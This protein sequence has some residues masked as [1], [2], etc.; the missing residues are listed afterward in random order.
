MDEQKSFDSLLTSL[1]ILGCMEGGDFIGTDNEKNIYCRY[2]SNWWNT[3][4]DL[5]RFETWTCTHDALKKIYCFDLPEYIKHANQL[6]E[7][8]EYIF[9]DL[10]MVCEHALK[11]VGRLKDTYNIRYQ[12]NTGGKYD[13][14][15]DT[16]I[17]SYAKIHI[18]HIDALMSKYKKKEEK[19]DILPMPVLKR[20]ESVIDPN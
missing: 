14:V 15:F 18:S 13:E 17:E 7:G 1:R 20:C 12:T 4:S 8:R 5:V 19:K 16:L 11:G 3:L 2:S 10:K 9:K 6:G